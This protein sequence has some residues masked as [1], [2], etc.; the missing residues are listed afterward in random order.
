MSGSMGGMGGGGI[1]A[2]LLA[3]KQRE[4]DK[5]NMDGMGDDDSGP[6]DQGSDPSDGPSDDDTSPEE[7]KMNAQ[8][9]DVLQS[10]YPKIFAK[11]QQQIQQPDDS[12][13]DQGPPG[14]AEQ[15]DAPMSG[16]M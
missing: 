13:S 6:D 7:N 8:I 9:V 4:A 5:S 3:L 10:T 1:G 2:L 15:S 11:I 12:D 14:M 16:M